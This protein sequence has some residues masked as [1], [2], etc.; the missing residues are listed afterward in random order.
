MCGVVAVGAV[1]VLMFSLWPLIAV[2]LIVGM[3]V[4]GYIKTRNKSLKWLS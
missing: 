4:V 2:P 1:G 3:V